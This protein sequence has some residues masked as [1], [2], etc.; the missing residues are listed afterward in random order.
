MSFDVVEGDPG[1][2]ATPQWRSEL[3][4]SSHKLAIHMKSLAHIIFAASSVLGDLAPH[5]EALHSGEPLP[6]IDILTEIDDV[7]RVLSLL[8]AHHYTAWNIRKQLILRSVEMPPSDSSSATENI[9]R[10]DQV[11]LESCLK[12]LKHISLAQTKRPKPS[13]SWAHRSWVLRT[14]EDLK[15]NYSKADIIKGEKHRCQ[16]AATGHK[17]NYYA[18]KHRLYLLQNWLSTP[19]ISTTAT[20]LDEESNLRE[21]FTA[22]WEWLKRNIQ[23][24]SAA[25]YCCTALKTLGW[26]KVATLTPSGDQGAALMS[27][28]TF[29]DE[30]SKYIDLYAAGETWWYIRRFLMAGAILHAFGANGT[31]DDVVECE[32]LFRNETVKI[33]Q[34]SA[35]DRQKLDS[36]RHGVWIS[37]FYSKALEKAQ[38]PVPESLSANMVVWMKQLE[39]LGWRPSL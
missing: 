16:A 38:V 31:P 27:L 2:T 12:E 17:R 39:S 32:T 19:L 9:H 10:T 28:E 8:N 20:K 37:T 18:W 25:H 36:L 35:D 3:Y 34:F 13:E 1:N 26:D 15:A 33:I 22:V 6:S 7:T 21:E 30:S 14:I 29:L 23:D 5:I 24:A 11:I 4:L